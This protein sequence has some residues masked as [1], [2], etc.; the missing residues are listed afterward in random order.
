MLI[1]MYNIELTNIINDQFKL[2]DITN[3][4]EIIIDP[5]NIYNSI[6]L[7]LFLSVCLPNF[8]ENIGNSL[9]NKKERVSDKV[10]INI[11]PSAQFVRN[12]S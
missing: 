9:T 7:L 10:G 4:D 3:I 11:N 12:E 1:N 5:I 6:I 2:N 8:K